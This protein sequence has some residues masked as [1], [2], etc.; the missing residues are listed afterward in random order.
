MKTM[1]C[2]LAY[3]ILCAIL[4]VS[5]SKNDSNPSSSSESDTNVPIAPTN[6]SV[7]NVDASSVKLTWTDASNNESGFKITRWSYMSGSGTTV[8]IPANTTTYTDV[9]LIT[10]EYEYS[11]CAYNSKGESAPTNN[12]DMGLGLQLPHLQTLLR[13]ASTRIRFL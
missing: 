2:F 1:Y 3:I 10:Y 5:C 11:V 13:I 6:L 9:G 7:A 8:S 12:V 4:L